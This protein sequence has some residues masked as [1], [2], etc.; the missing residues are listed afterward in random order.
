MAEGG[1]QRTGLVQIHGE[2]RRTDLADRSR[3]P[4]LVER[5]V[6]PVTTAQHQGEPGRAVLHE[7]LDAA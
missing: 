6:G 2:V 1:Q 7:Q 5:D 3:E 4:Q